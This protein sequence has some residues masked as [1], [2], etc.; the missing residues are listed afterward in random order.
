MKVIKKPVPF[1][2]KEEHQQSFQTLIEKLTTPPVLAYADCRLPFSVHTDASL[3]GLGAVLYQ[4]Q[5]NKERVVAYASRSLKPE[6]F[7]KEL[8]S[9]Q[10]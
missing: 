8:S 7:R 5:D 2:W 4:K 1:E 3:N 6:A 9:A 10:A